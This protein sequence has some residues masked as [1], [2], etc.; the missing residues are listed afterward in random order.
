MK[1]RLLGLIAALCLLPGFVSAASYIDN[2]DQTVTDQVTGL[3]WDQ[4]DTTTKTWEAGLAY[5]EAMTHGSKTDWRLPNR[6]ELES[7]VDETKTSSPT[8]NTTF[9]PDTVSGSYW[10]STSYALGTTSAWGVNFN[11][12]G[13]SFFKKTFNYYVRCVR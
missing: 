9:F 1:K 12:G 11:S 7:L 2:G 13:V 8:I 6:N 5:C 4:R 3:M 10:T